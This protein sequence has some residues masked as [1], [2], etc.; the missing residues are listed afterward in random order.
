MGKV[1]E[2]TSKITDA[3]LK[4]IQELSMEQQRIMN[5]V[6]E[7]EV[8]KSYALKAFDIG[9][10]KLK[11]IRATLQGKYGDV[12]IDTRTGEITPMKNAKKN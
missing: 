2:I 8:R 7:I 10:A 11:E 12:N 1:K 4:E 9:D 6:G 3:E 5:Q